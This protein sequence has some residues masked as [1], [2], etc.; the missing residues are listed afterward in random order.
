MIQTTMAEEDMK[1]AQKRLYSFMGGMLFI[2]I[3]FWG[4]AVLNSTTKGFFDLGC[5]SFPT[6]ALS[7][8]YV[9]YQLRE[10][11]IVTRRSSPMFGNITKAFVCATY[12]IVALNYLLG[13]YIMVNMDPLQIGKTIYFGVFTILWFVAA[14]LALKYISQVNNSKEEGA[15]SENSALRQEHFS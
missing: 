15:A 10:S 13:V 7:S 4:W 9:L 11:A 1:L 14:F 8:A 12:T 6:A 3:F 5:V 2:S